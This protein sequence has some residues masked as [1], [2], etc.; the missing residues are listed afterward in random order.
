MVE[1]TSLSQVISGLR[2]ALAD[3]S[4]DSRYIQTVPRR[5]FRF[6]ATV[7]ELPDAANERVPIAATG[8]VWQGE[9]RPVPAS[10]LIAEP[11]GSHAVGDG[12][13]VSG[14]RRLLRVALAGGVAT[15]L[16]GVWWWASRSAS[17]AGAAAHLSTL[18]VLPFKPLVSDA[19][20]ELLEVG[21][22]DSLIAR[23]S[24]VPG[25]S[26]VQLGRCVAMRVPT[27]TLQAA[28]NLDVAWIVDGSLQR[29][30]DQLRYRAIAPRRRRRRLEVAASTRN[31]QGFRVQ[32]MISARVARYSRSLASS[33]VRAHR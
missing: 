27:R 4:H 30:G 12:A 23:L 8:S 11:A 21:M 28:R 33:L 16:G 18:A 31:S 19:R 14:R 1:E 26:C 7:T 22:A 10:E 2:R 13:R 29:R 25:W 20:D 3:D 32:D 5:G 6:I 24:T 15:G 17:K 9:P